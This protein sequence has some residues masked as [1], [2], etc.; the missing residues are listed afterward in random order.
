MALILGI[1]VGTTGTKT[2]LM[3]E[4]GTILSTACQGYQL[5]C[6]N[7]FVEQDADDWWAAIVKTVRKN[8]EVAK[9]RISAV[10]LSS[11]GATLLPESVLLRKNML[12]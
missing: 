6:Q 3:D 2:I 1:D 7:G 9:D 11:Q 4:N 10:A 12:I 5:H 8:L